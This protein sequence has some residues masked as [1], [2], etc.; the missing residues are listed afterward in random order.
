MENHNGRNCRSIA[1]ASHDPCLYACI[2]EHQEF[3]PRRYSFEERLKGTVRNSLNRIST[4][5]TGKLYFEIYSYATANGLDDN[6]NRGDMAIRR[7]VQSQFRAAFAPRPVNF[8]EIGW[9]GLTEEKIDHVNRHAD[10]FVIAGGGYIFVNADGSAGAMLAKISDLTRLKCPIVAVG[11]GLNRLMHE[12][13]CAL[14]DLDPE[15]RDKMKQLSSLCRAISVRDQDTADLFA[16]Y[17]N[18]P[19]TVTGDPVL[20]FSEGDPLSTARAGPLTIGVNFAVHGPRAYSLLAPVMPRIVASLKW[21]QQAY[22][23]DMTYLLHHDLER[24]IVAYLQQKGAAPGD[25]RWDRHTTNRF[26]Q[27]G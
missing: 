27:P 12:T 3:A 10:L 13:P 11:I 22:R 19:A 17:G 21:V 8:L 9:R 2:P 14:S 1:E 26:V 4:R 25:R 24:P 20:Y 7:A 16:L 15:A 5:L 6:S 18:K 23:A